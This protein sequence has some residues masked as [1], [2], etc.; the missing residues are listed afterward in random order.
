M[1]RLSRDD[2]R[3]VIE[4]LQQLAALDPSRA[5]HLDLAR[6]LERLTQRARQA[7]ANF[8]KGGAPQPRTRSQQHVP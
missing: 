8:A 5:A 7:G 4:A 2:A 1:P 3:R 6:V